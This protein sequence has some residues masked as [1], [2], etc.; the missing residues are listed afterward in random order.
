MRNKTKFYLLVIFMLIPI[1]IIIPQ[2]NPTRVV[3]DITLN[4]K[5]S[6]EAGT[7]LSYFINSELKK[8]KNVETVEDNEDF[9]INVMMFENRTKEGDTLG[10]VISAI[11]L[12]PADCDGYGAYKYLTSTLSTARK[13]EFEIAAKNIVAYFDEDVLKLRK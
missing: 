1:H 12:A 13:S 2:N 4:Q 11:F 5:T 7:R 8:L 3:V 9:K 10:Y 6:N